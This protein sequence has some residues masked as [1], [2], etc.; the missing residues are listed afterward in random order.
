[1]LKNAKPIYILTEYLSTTR[2]KFEY[3][4]PAASESIKRNTYKAYE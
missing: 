2:L 4:M 1:M 3:D